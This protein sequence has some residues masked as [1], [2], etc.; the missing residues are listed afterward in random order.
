MTADAENAVDGR[1]QYGGCEENA[2]SELGFFFGDRSF[3]ET[4]FETM[5]EIWHQTDGPEVLVEP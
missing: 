2:T 1:C 3:C 4:H 5:T